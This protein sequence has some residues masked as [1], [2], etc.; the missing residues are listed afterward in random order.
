MTAIDLTSYRTLKVSQEGAVLTVMLSNP[1]KRNAYT[2][3]MGRDLDR[4]WRE[5][6]YDENIR[7]VVLTGE[8]DAFCAGLDLSYLSGEPESGLKKI[9]KG[10]TKGTRTRQRIAVSFIPRP[11]SWPRLATENCWSKSSPR[12]SI[13]TVT[14]MAQSMTS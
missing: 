12:P 6:D 8:G 13:R 14:D 9:S 2:P 1:G 10:Q 4:L 11:S 7:V 5:V 3:A